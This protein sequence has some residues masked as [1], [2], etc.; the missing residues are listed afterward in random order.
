MGLSTEKNIGAYS[1]NEQRNILPI[2]NK[3]LK[4]KGPYLRPESLKLNIFVI[5]L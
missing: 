2:K 1:K 3:I 4:K 5:I